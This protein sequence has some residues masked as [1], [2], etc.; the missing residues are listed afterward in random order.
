MPFTKVSYEFLADDASLFAIR[1]ERDS[2]YSHKS[3]FRRHEATFPCC[4]PTRKSPVKTFFLR[5]SAQLDPVRA[6]GWRL[7]REN[8]LMSYFIS[9]K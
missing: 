9:A 6:G 3:A 2:K 4:A 1:F 7:L 5:S 8:S